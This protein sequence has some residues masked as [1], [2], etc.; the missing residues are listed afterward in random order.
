MDARQTAGD[1]NEE[2]VVMVKKAEN[3]L[4]EHL[5]IHIYINI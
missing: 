2:L 3:D 4:Q 1:D 5:L